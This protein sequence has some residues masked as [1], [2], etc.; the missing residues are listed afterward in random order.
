[1]A[2]LLETGRIFAPPAGSRSKADRKDRAFIGLAAGA[3]ICAAVW[4]LP[5]PGLMPD[6]KKCLAM[7]LCAVCWWATG[8]MHPGYT[9][10]AL[11]A[12]YTL[13][14]DSKLAPAATVFGLW[15]TPTM[16]L[17][18]GGFLIAKAVEAS[19]L[20]RR[21]ALAFISRF[22][23]SY[24]G[25]VFSCY[26][27]G[28]LLSFVI[29]H[30]WPRSFLLLSVMSHAA[31]SAG[32]SQRAAANLGLAVF[33]ASVPASM[34]LLTGDSTLNPIVG[35]FVAGT[36]VSWLQWL[37]YMGPPGLLAL[38]LTGTVQLLSYR[39]REEFQLDL[40]QVRCQLADMG[41]LTRPEMRVIAVMAAAVLLW[42]TDSL[43]GLH[44]GWVAL[45]AALSFAM[46]PRAL[47]D[48]KSWS[49]VNLGTLFFL[50]AALAIGSVGKAVGM[51]AWLAELIIPQQTVRSP[52]LFALTAMLICMAL[53]MALGSTLAVL[54][55]ACP[56][57]ISFGTAAGIAP[58]AAALIAYTS[59]ALHWL[60]PFH[61]MNLLV[62]CGEDGGG[63]EKR[64][65]LRLGIPQ[66]AVV[67][68]VVLFEV[69]WWNIIGIF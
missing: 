44:P 67:A 24:G 37:V 43:H 32:L 4:L 48:A 59:V 61:H 5:I 36:T 42:M 18:I 56:A 6:G 65:V 52:Y 28:L 12:G 3:V 63:F 68:A 57:I 33:V 23:R 35:G 54:G 22:T 58:L 46:P 15:T 9:A 2:G 11:L 14:L 20:G 19:G 8:A 62:G 17:V 39:Q 66:T 29:P 45:I 25:M 64:D 26:L 1:M 21:A 41:K 53:H 49:G 40:A 10:L 50:C 51:N 69:L 34:I 38:A 13:F 31:R 60:L 47:L 7:S 16:Y 27:L 55:I 30:P